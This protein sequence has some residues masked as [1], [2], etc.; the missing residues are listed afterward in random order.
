VPALRETDRVL[1]ILGRQ[2][3]VLANLVRD[4]D[5]VIHA[6]TGNRRDVVRRVKETR[7]TAAASAERRAAIAEGLRKLPEFLRQL[8]PTM[9]E[10]GQVADAQQ[11]SLRDLG[12]SADQ[13]DRLFTNLAPFSQS[14]QVNLRSLGQAAR[15]G[16]PA[17]KAARPVI[18]ALDQF[19]VKTPEVANN[20]AI[21]L[22]DSSTSSS[23]RSR[24]TSTTPTATCSRRTSSTRSART[25]RAPSR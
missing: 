8:R 13:L 3:Q 24:S 7:Q 22:R 25:T 20:L 12:A 19:S 1:A 23:R 10:L 15:E 2:N 9:A 21:I 18:K 14:T 4:G 17:V 16:D 5:Q 6:M 11:P